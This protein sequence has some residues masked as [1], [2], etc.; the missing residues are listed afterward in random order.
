MCADKDYEK[1]INIEFM[2][3]FMIRIDM[4]TGFVPLLG[5]RLLSWLIKS[6]A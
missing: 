6:T 4:S 5:C 1:K 3:P 2:S